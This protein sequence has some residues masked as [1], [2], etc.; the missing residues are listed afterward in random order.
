MAAVWGAFETKK[1]TELCCINIGRATVG[2]QPSLCSP[3]SF[4][5]FWSRC[6]SPWKRLLQNNLIWS[7][8]CHFVLVEDRQ[9]DYFIFLLFFL[10]GRLTERC[11]FL[12]PACVRVSMCTYVGVCVRVRAYV[13]VCMCWIPVVSLLLLLPSFS[14]SFLSRLLPPPPLLFLCV[15]VCVLFFL[16]LFPPAL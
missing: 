10:R 7:D 5:P 16:S 11:N 2:S 6:L 12:V 4:S 9:L 13:C 15:C 14:S 1:S 8:W 3:H